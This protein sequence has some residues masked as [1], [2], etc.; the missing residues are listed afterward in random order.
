MQGSFE[1][2]SGHFN[3][4]THDSYELLSDKKCMVHCFYLIKYNYAYIFNSYSTKYGRLT[5]LL[6]IVV[7]MHC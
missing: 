3:R 1:L 2:L 6:V 5:F 7:N 4:K